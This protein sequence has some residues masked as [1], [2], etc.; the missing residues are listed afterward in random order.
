MVVCNGHHAT[1]CITYSLFRVSHYV[2]SISC[3]LKLRVDRV[4]AHL[5]QLQRKPELKEV[6][7]TYGKKTKDI[8]SR[9]KS[10]KEEW[11]D[12]EAATTQAVPTRIKIFEGGSVHLFTII[13]FKWR[14]AT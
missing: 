9:G 8:G 2:A 5:I 13:T 7:I 6:D 10:A 12:R 3:V 1:T 14:K 11:K 4:F